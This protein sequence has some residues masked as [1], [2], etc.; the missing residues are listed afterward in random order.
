MSHQKRLYVAS[1]TVI[2]QGIN[3]YMSRQKGLYVPADKGYMQ[4]ETLICRQR[5]A[6]MLRQRGYMSGQRAYMLDDIRLICL[7]HN[8][9]MSPSEPLYVSVISR[10]CHRQKAYMFS[11]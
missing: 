5:R 10:I 1:E 8:A 4:A 7:G 11:S 3:G 9:H 6:Y 2:C